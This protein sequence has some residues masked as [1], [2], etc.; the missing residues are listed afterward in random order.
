MP[1]VPPEGEQI[2]TPKNSGK[3]RFLF[4]VAFLSAE[5]LTK[6]AA[7]EKGFSTFSG[8]FQVRGVSTGGI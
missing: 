1:E 4:F 5:A 2:Y 8:Y 3:A 7:K 6:V